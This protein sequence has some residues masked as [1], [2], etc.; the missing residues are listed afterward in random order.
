MTTRSVVTA[1]DNTYIRIIGYVLIGYV[2]DDYVAGYEQSPLTW[3]PAATA[4]D[5]WTSAF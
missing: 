3:T 5:T 1:A 2:E 4:N